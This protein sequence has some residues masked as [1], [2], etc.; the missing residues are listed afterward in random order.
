MFE[1]ARRVARLL[2]AGR[3]EN[4]VASNRATG[5]EM[6]REQ[7][8]IVTPKLLD[9][10]DCGRLDAHLDAMNGHLP[11]DRTLLDARWCRDLARHLASHPLLAN[12]L[13]R[14]HVAVQC[15]YFE[16]SL[17]QNWL[18]PLHQDLSVPV[19][20]KVAHT[21]L[22]GWSRKG[23]QVFVQPPAALLELLIAVRL[24]LDDCSCDDGPLMVVPGSHRQ[25]RLNS[26]QASAARDRDGT[27]A[28]EVA[29]GAALVFHPLL[30]HAS[31]KATGQ[32]R[33]RVLH[34][35]FAPKVPPFGL[36]WSN[37]A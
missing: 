11:G 20:E 15:T 8:Y 27:V 9:E 10:Q 24:H 37:V 4:L 7:G 36:R 28:C 13:P 18:V 3:A 19:A 22:T 16:K 2:A 17:L 23:D 25:G 1:P 26:H 33:R 21:A 30:L 5:A 34:F 35:L 32:S 29:R 6:L 31:S 12:L 14:E